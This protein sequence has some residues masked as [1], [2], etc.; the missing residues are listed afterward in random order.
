MA[1]YVPASLGKSRRSVG[2]NARATHR[3]A[4]SHSHLS[5]R[6]RHSRSPVLRHPCSRPHPRIR[7]NS[8][9]RRTL[10]P[11]ESARAHRPRT[12]AI[13]HHGSSPGISAAHSRRRLACVHK[14]AVSIQTNANL[15]VLT[16]QNGTFLAFHPSK[17]NFCNERLSVAGGFFVINQQPGCPPLEIY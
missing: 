5:R 10:P 11:D 3:T 6:A 7:S 17:A 4:D 12:P 1:S 15:R 2:L 16:R 14:R 13:L 9:R 8:P